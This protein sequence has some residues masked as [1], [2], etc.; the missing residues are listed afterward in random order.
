MAILGRYSVTRSANILEESVKYAKRSESILAKIKTGAIIPH[1]PN[2]LPHIFTKKH[3]WDKFI[4]LTGDHKKDFE[5]LVLFLE[6]Q[7]ILQ[8][9][10]EINW[11]FKGITAYKYTKRIGRDRIVALFEI[12]KA[13]LPLLRNAW[14]EI[15]TPYVP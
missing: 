11:A 4:K 10:R 3:H 15:G 2:V 7:K 9:D 14:V 13:N 12:N 6:K 1:N 8:C 5:T